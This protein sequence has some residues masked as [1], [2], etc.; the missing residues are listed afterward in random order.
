VVVAQQEGIILMHW[1]W[2][3]PL[4]SM[5]AKSPFIDLTHASFNN[6]YVHYLH[7]IRQYNNDSNRCSISLKETVNHI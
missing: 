1:G 5:T 6:Y 7:F 2:Q 4:L 3:C